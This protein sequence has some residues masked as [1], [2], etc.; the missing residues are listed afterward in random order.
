MSHLDADFNLDVAA[1]NRKYAASKD[2]PRRTWTGTFQ[3]PKGISQSM[4][5]R[6]SQARCG[7]FVE[8]LNKKGWD[9][10]GR[11]QVFGPFACH[12]LQT[13]VVLLDQNEYRVRG[14]FRLRKPEPVRIEIPS[15]PHKRNLVMV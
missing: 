1:L 14:P 11:L 2:D 4:F 15:R 10:I 13:A 6:L 3:V 9:L 12:D 8:A 5:E 7:R